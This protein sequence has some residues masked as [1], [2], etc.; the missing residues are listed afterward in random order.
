[1]IT[2]FKIFEQTGKFVNV[3]YKIIAHDLKDNPILLITDF[4]IIKLESKKSIIKGKGYIKENLQGYNT[5][6]KKFWVEFNDFENDNTRVVWNKNFKNG[7]KK[8]KVII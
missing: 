1:M 8:I 3:N 4:K 5:K 6:N 7:T 2:K